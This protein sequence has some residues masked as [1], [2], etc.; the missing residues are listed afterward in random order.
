M[1]EHTPAQAQGYQD[2][3]IERPEQVP[4]NLQDVQNLYAL[5]HWQ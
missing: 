4:H 2:S 1:S 5:W 3:S